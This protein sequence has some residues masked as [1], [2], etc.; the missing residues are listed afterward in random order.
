MGTASWGVLTSTTQAVRK[1][2]VACLRERGVGREDDDF[3]ELFGAVC[4]GVQFAMRAS[5]T[6]AAALDRVEARRY[7]V[8]HLD[9]YRP[10]T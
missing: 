1:V 7:A 5:M 3:K 2:V 9:M 8:G 6:T 10:T 4:K